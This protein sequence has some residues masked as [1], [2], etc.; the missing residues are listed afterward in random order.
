LME[1]LIGET[2]LARLRFMTS[3]P[4]DLSKHLLEVMAGSDRIMPHI[5]L[6]LQSGS[7]RVLEAMGRKYTVEHYLEIVGSIREKLPYVS[8]TTDLM[9][10]F[11]TETEEEYDQTLQVVKKVQFDSAFMFR[12]SVRP[13]TAAARQVDDVPENVK[14][15]RL[16]KLIEL[17]QI[18]SYDR[19]QREVGRVVRCLVE[20]VSRRDTAMMRGRTEG[21]KIVLFKTGA[22][23]GDIVSVS[24]SSA[25]A[26]TLHGHVMEEN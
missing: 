19:N 24:I 25:D 8:L 6:P 10:G 2:D 3:H 26:Y 13:G 11:P 5:H 12:Y 23:E 14:I 9:V 1:R 21:N 4:K 22:K 18:I 7:S 16:Q 20:G 17:Q 15:E